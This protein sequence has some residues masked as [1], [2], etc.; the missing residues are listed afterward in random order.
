MV[1]KVSTINLKPAPISS[2]VYGGTSSGGSAGQP[3]PKVSTRQ[4]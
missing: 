1:S 4:L 3:L 2:T